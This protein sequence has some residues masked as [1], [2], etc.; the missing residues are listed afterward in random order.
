M[1]SN[2]IDRMDLG[3]IKAEEIVGSAGNKGTHYTI[4]I[5]PGIERIPNSGREN[6]NQIGDR[7]TTD[8]I[9]RAFCS[10]VA[11]TRRQLYWPAEF[12]SSLPAG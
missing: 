12:V 6:Q 9:L 5:Q 11:Q 10:H 1:S 8:R 7:L 3:C 2:L 4:D